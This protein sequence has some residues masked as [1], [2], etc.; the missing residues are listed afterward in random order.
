MP[1]VVETYRDLTVWAKSADLV[2]AVYRVTAG[3]PRAELYGLASQIRRAAVS[4]PA[5]VAEGNSRPSTPAYLHHV[6]IALGSHGELRALLDIGGRVGFIGDTE[7]R[8]LNG[9]VDEVGRLLAG[10]HRAL[11]ARLTAP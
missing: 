11:K 3:F 6:S 4:I 7:L 10:L 5:N 9:Q 1:V 8:S 2:V